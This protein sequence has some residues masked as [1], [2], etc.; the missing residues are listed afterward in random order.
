MVV[1]SI[2]AY[3]DDIIYA[4]LYPVND[5]DFV[6][7]VWVRYYVYMSEDVAE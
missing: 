6:G 4:L 3:C 5:F 2:I 1:G 7:V